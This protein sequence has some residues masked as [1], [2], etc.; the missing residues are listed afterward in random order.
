MELI[1]SIYN[2]A[3]AFGTGLIHTG[4]SIK[5]GAL[6]I[7]EE[8]SHAMREA[9]CLDGFEKLTKAGIANLKFLNIIPCIKGV[10]DECIA[11]LEAQK[12]LYYATKFFDCMPD[13]IYVDPKTKA[14]SFQLPRIQKG[15]DKGSID[16]V[17]ILY[18]IGNF[19]DPFR[20][21]YKYKIY[22]FPLCVEIANRMASIKVFDL[23]GKTYTIDDIPVV[24][25]LCSRPK[26][27]FIFLASLVDVYRC[28]KKTILEWENGL[29]LVATCG[30]IVLITFGRHHH[31]MLWFHIADVITQNVGLMA[32]IVKRH[33]DRE[34]RFN[35]PGE[36]V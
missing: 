19:L 14:K 35:H 23:N 9:Y 2:A 6:V 12:D 31:K 11:T 5:K 18:A 13:F 15:P 25:S 30:R 22:S 8:G 36:P 32:F 7:A 3:A 21:L 17:K 33:I 1:N 28:S 26:D 20:F 34:R 29:K 4:E 10:F 16:S 24:H 27:F